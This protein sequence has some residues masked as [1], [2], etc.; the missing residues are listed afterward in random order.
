[1]TLSFTKPLRGP[2]MRG[3]I[4]CT[5]RIWR[6]LRVKTGG[7][8]A[9]GPGQVEVTRIQHVD[10]EDITEEIA[11][12]SGFRDLQDLMAVARHG[13]GENVYLIDFVYEGPEPAQ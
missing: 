8:Y 10:L 1:M 7:R 12:A 3:E 6:N 2:I 11:R 9:L 4:T 13:S 5:V